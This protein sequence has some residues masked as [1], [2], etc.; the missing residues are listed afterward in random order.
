MKWF[1][2]VSD[3]LDDPF[4]FDLIDTYGGDGYLVF[5]GTLEIMSREFDV[6]NPGN[7]QVSVKFLTKKL[8]LSTK[9]VT[10]VLQ[11][12]A[13]NNRIYFSIDK[14]T[15]SLN[16]PK[17][18]KMCDEFTNKVLKA[19]SGVNPDPIGSES[20]TEVRSKKKE[21]RS[22]NKDIDNKISVMDNISLTDKEIEK[23]QADFGGDIYSRAVRYLSDYKKEKN[24]KTRDDNLTIR[25][26]VI[27][28][29]AK[30]G[31]GNGSNRQNDTR[32]QREA[33]GKTKGD[34]APYPVDAICTE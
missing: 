30:Q 32:G 4:I 26:W 31:G 14:D 21:V 8:Q 9:L 10:K 18:I 22:K 23:L 17:L 6:N 12:C 15:I 2:H 33:T 13:E 25:R 7:C 29:V 16:C 1:K 3:S 27:E 34:G 5:F 24:Y 11:F 28:A 19:K 20:G